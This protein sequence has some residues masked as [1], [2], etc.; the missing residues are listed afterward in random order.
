MGSI[1]GSGRSP[2]GGYRNPLQYS[3]LE[4]PTDREAWQVRVLRLPESRPW[5]KRFS[6]HNVSKGNLYLKYRYI[7]YWGFPSSSAYSA[8]AAG[9]TGSVPVSGRFSAGGLWQPSPVFL[10][11]ESHGER[12]LAGYSP[13][14]Q[15][16]GHNWSDLARHGIYYITLYYI[17]I[18]LNMSPLNVSP[19]I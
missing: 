16:V 14:L 9:D 3:G 4:N 2:G 5:L 17:L 11:G 1:P 10:P 19:L 15:R 6:T 12:C 8:G 13:E 18:K 7:L